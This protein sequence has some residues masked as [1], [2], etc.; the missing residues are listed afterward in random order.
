MSENRW[1]NNYLGLYNAVTFKR[2]QQWMMLGKSLGL[3]ALEEFL[4]F[5][6]YTEVLKTFEQG[7]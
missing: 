6:M 2:L 3:G 5:C 4:G 7:W 1:K